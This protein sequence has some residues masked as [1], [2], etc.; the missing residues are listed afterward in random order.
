VFITSYCA[1]TSGSETEEKVMATGKY[2]I[3]NRAKTDDPGLFPVSVKLEFGKP[4][5][6]SVGMYVVTYKSGR[7]N[8][9]R[10]SCVNMN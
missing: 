9:V 7:L 1:I 5:T 2:F 4:Q 10:V 3:S 8:R 6:S